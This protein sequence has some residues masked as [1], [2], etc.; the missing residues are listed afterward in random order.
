MY[1]VQTY[2]E[3]FRE[4]RQDIYK[5]R[6]LEIPRPELYVI[7]TGEREKRPEEISFLEEFSGGDLVWM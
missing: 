1:L 2:R 7:Y 4:T 3:Y 5:S 6:K